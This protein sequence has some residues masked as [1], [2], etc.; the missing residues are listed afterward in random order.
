MGRIEDVAKS[1]NVSGVFAAQATEQS[2]S[3]EAGEYF[4]EF[5]YERHSLFSGFILSRA[6]GWKHSDEPFAT[7][8]SSDSPSNGICSSL[9]KDMPVCG[10]PL[11]D[12]E[13]KSMRL[14]LGDIR[15]SFEFYKGLGV[16]QKTMITM[17]PTTKRILW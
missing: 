17:G 2:Y 15:S 1:S 14:S 7:I 3:D 4:E 10:T 8:P 9:L 6:M 13:L 5:N 12:D 11:S 16:Y